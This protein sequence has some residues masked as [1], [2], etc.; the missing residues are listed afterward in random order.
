MNRVTQHVEMCMRFARELGTSLDTAGYKPCLDE[1][2]IFVSLTESEIGEAWQVGTARRSMSEN[3]DDT[4]NYDGSTEM[5]VRINQIGALPE[6]AVRKALGLSVPLTIGTYKQ[7]DLPY[8]IEARLIGVENYGLRVKLT[9]APDRRVVGVV[10][11]QGKEYQPYRI[12]GWC[13][14]HEARMSE[15]LQDFGDRSK[16]I[17]AV[18]Q[19]YLRPW[20]ELMEIIKRER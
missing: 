9:D 10:I 3:Q 6:A 16:P 8:N 13:Y 15:W 17:H 14:A 4:E 12:P 18:P 2:N 1:H 11:E 5:A 20:S 19:H 7:A